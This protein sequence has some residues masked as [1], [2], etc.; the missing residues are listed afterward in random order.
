MKSIWLTNYPPNN[1]LFLTS[2]QAFNIVAEYDS[3][4]S[5]RL[6]KAMQVDSFSMRTI[7]VLGLL[8]L[9]GTFICVGYHLAR[10]GLTKANWI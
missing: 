8:F 5:V 1:K 10:V 2:K 3:R 4:I 7:A 6:S 9:P